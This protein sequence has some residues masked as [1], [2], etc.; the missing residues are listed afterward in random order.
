MSGLA[1]AASAFKKAVGGTVVA[2][3]SVAGS[4]SSMSSTTGA[5][6][7]GGAAG[8]WPDAKQK[9]NQSLLPVGELRYHKAQ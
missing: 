2:G 3:E 9:T 8:K 5:A 1:K 7:A 6:T 4:G